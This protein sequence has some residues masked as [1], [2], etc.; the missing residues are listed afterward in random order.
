MSKVIKIKKGLDI[1]LKGKAEKIFVKSEIA[2]SYCIKPTDFKGI[3]P[4]LT[5]KPDDSVLAGS[6]LFHDKNNPDLLFTSPVSGKIKDI[7][8]GERRKILEVIIEP[9]A[10]IEYEQFV[11]GDA[12]SMDRETI[13]QN[14]LK[15]GTWPLIRQR[16]YGTIANTQDKPKSIFISAY[17]SAPLAPDNDF[18]VKDHE[19]EFQA[20]I[21][22]LS[23]LTDGTIHVNVNGDFPVSNVYINT[24]G[25]AINN[26]S[27]PHPSGNVGVQIHK[28]DPINKGEIVW[29]LYPQDVITIGRLF[30][31]GKYDASKTIA[32]TG[33][34][35]LKPRYYKIISGTSIKDLVYNNVTD[36]QNKRQ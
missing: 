13:V 12:K 24:K 30:I 10:E 18:V 33:S 17:D 7:V 28:I 6:S 15:S 29:Y 35:V 3:V 34:E 4:K 31:E 8:R 16:P 23:K 25:I 11:K 1:N 14:M 22:V 9:D 5:V 26:F 36:N 27:G 32:L 21:D 20:G 19:T 2:N